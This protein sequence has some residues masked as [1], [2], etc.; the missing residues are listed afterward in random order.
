VI[1]NKEISAGV[2]QIIAR[3][4]LYTI[5]ANQR[6]MNSNGFPSSAQANKTM[7]VVSSIKDANRIK[8][9]K[10]ALTIDRNG[11]TDLCKE[12]R[13]EPQVSTVA[14]YSRFAVTVSTRG[15]GEE[16]Y[17]KGSKRDSLQY[18]RARRSALINNNT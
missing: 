15:A 8:A 17:G 2:Q 4:F 6:V 10:L 7:P 3:T 1:Y 16:G 14:V 13:R 11:S 5:K 9:E 12:H 18:C